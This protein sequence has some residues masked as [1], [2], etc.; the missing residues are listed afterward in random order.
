[1]IR[2]RIPLGCFFGY[3]MEH[4]RGRLLYEGHLSYDRVFASPHLD[5]FTSPASYMDRRADGT[6]GFMTCID[7]ILW[8]G[9]S[10]WL[11]LD[12]ITHLLR[13]GNANGRPIPGHDSAF[14]NEAE[15]VGRTAARVCHVPGSWRPRLVV[16]HVRRLVRQ[17]QRHERK[18]SACGKSA[19]SSAANRTCRPRWPSSSTP[20][21]CTTS[22]GVRPSHVPSSPSNVPLSLVW[23]RP[24]KSTRW[25][26]CRNSTC[27]DFAW[28][29]S[30]TCFPSHQK[31]RHGWNKRS[32]ATTNTWSSP[33]H[34]GSSPTTATT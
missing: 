26:T 2:H 5:F 12:H 29:S 25:L 34:Q 19:I 33:T 21:R 9:K 23:V 24:G 22:T 14:Q 32:S 8:R 7:S 4:N 28:S 27:P 15:T 11:E 20:I 1:M 3:V 30:P 18:S 6:G 16:R 13:D 31:K 10:A 17:P